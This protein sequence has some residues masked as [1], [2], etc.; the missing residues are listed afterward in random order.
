[1]WQRPVCLHVTHRSN[2]SDG[3]SVDRRF[4]MWHNTRP[5]RH[6]CL[7]MARRQAMPV[8]AFMTPRGEAYQSTKTPPQESD[9]C[10]CDMRAHFALSHGCT[11]CTCAHMQ[12]PAHALAAAMHVT[13]AGPTG[14]LHTPGLVAVWGAYLNDL[15]L[16]DAP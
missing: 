16:M 10:I 14:A 4:A 6:V 13:V 2:P 15:A 3:G 12:A 7:T 8:L 5:A 9:I 11:W 1:M